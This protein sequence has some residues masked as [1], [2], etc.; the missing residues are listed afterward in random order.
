[1]LGQLR[2]Y[3]KGNGAKEIGMNASEA[4]TLMDDV[5]NEIQKRADKIKVQ[6]RTIVERDAVI[7]Q[8]RELLRKGF[9]TEV[10]YKKEGKDLTVEITFRSG[11]PMAAFHRTGKPPTG[12]P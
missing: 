8:G 3:E 12:S 1:M 5:E 2:Q 9:V 6:C 7:G 11:G 10:E 4:S